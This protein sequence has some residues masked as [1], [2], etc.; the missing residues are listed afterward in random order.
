MGGGSACQRLGTVGVKERVFYS[1]N[2]L[3]S[4]C[5]AALGQAVGGIQVVSGLEKRG[6]EADGRNDWSR[7]Q[8]RDESRGRGDS[9]GQGIEREELRVVFL[10]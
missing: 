7:E 1:I 2:E 5:N 8:E 6:E 3:L 9:Q 10:Q 4:R